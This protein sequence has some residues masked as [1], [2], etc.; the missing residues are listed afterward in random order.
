MLELKPAFLHQLA[1]HCLVAEPATAP[2]AWSQYQKSSKS[3]DPTRALRV[4]TSTGPKTLLV[5][6][7]VP[8]TYML[9][10]KQQ[11]VGRG[12]FCLFF[13]PLQLASLVE[14]YRHVDVGHACCLFC[15]LALLRTGWRPPTRERKTRT[16]QE[17]LNFLQAC[18]GACRSQRVMTST[19]RYLSFGS[20]LQTDTVPPKLRS[21]PPTSAELG[22]LQT[23]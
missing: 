3:V 18:G 20:T 23:C 13:S 14:P 5:T 17:P 12:L 19:L 15:P 1:A 10:C 7:T 9:N 8:T 21:A 22:T 16:H 4:H 6:C 11:L 2:S